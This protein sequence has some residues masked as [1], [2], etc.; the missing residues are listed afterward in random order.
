MVGFGPAWISRRGLAWV[1]TFNTIGKAR[2]GRARTGKAWAGR[3]TA[4]LGEVGISRL[5]VA[6]H[7]VA[8]LG[9]EWA[10][11]RDIVAR[12]G[13]TWRGMAG[14]GP[15]WFCGERRGVTATLTSGRYYVR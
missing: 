8:R 11:G 1:G 14:T 13:E 7:G 10:L 2:L 6:G 9:A 5:G 3:G 12:H 4:R 15:A